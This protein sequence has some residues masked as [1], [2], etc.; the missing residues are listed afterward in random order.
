[1]FE[2][3]SSIVT[4]LITPGPFPRYPLPPWPACQ[5]DSLSLYI[6]RG[7]GLAVRKP[8]EKRLTRKKKKH[9]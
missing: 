5:Y 1:M 9:H 8:R 3:R 4:S 2:S 6:I 7:A